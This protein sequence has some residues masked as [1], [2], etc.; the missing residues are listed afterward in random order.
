[1]HQCPQA[2][3]NRIARMEPLDP[4]WRKVMEI[5][6]EKAEEAYRM[7]DDL[8]EKVTKDPTVVLAFRV[9][10]PLLMENEAISSFIVET[11]QGALRTSLPEVIST[12]EAVSLATA[13]YR[14]TPYQ[15]KVLKHALITARQSTRPAQ[16]R[17]QPKA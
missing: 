8:A 5:P 7:V 17:P 11:G 15:Q 14:L 12:A 9:L 2:I 13:E 16:R 10:A 6:P 1:M 3:W 4:F